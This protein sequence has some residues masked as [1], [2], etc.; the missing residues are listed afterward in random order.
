MA[1]AA[2]NRAGDSVVSKAGQPAD[3]AVNQATPAKVAPTTVPDA[4]TPLSEPSG[5]IDPKSAEA[6]G[7]IVQSYGGLIEQ[8][9]WTEANALWGDP[10]MAQKWQSEL[11]QFVDVH[12]EIGDLGETEGAAGS[13]YVTMPVIFY[14]QL[15]DGKAS[16]RS[17]DVVQRRV[18]DVPGSSAAQR[19]WHIE[20]IEWKPAA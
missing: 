10:G 4:R 5:P 9:R 20:R 3:D 6:A 15:K 13:I 11:S 14:G 16:R 8:K 17:A 18:N 19:R 7:Q 2:C 12:L 1:L